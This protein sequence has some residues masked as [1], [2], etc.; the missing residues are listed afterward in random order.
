MNFSLQWVQTYISKFGGDP[1]R[2]TIAGESAG[3]GAVMLQSMAFGGSLGTS[4]FNNGIVA[5]PYLPM[6]YDYD[7]LLPEESYRKFVE[8]VGC[9]KSNGSA[10]DCLIS[11]D[12]IA[13]QNASSHISAGVNY[14]QWAF[15]P[16][17]DGEFLVKRPSQQLLAG[18][19]NGVRMLSGVSTPFNY[20]F[21]HRTRS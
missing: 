11:A 17:T 2:V 18:E 14:G 8:A 5:S 4:L 9:G 21:K 10:F 20:I 15:L 19:V 3:G 13:L 12:T 6:Q 7:G 1:S 16:V